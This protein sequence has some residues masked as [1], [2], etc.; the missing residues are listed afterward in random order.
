MELDETRWGGEGDG[1]EERDQ[2][3]FPE[4]KERKKRHTFL[5][6][7]GGRNVKKKGGSFGKERGRGKPLEEN[8]REGNDE[9]K[10]KVL[11]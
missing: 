7:G 4:K 8:A 2:G 3:R 5:R 9:K 10:G 1:R 11:Y 6:K